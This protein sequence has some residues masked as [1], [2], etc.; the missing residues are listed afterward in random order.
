MNKIT[1]I[2]DD[3]GT[4]RINHDKLATDIVKCSAMLEARFEIFNE[5]SNVFKL[6]FESIVNF[7]KI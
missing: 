3:V 4:I 7:A 6:H 2:T 5:H 1:Q